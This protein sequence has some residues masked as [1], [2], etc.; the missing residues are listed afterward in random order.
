VGGLDHP[1]VA[2]ARGASPRQ[3]NQNSGLDE[4]FP[5]ATSFFIFL[6][7]GRKR[8]FRLLVMG[9]VLGFFCSGVLKRSF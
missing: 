2:L 1:F 8:Q 4:S 3:G 7:M 5:L 6:M 9:G